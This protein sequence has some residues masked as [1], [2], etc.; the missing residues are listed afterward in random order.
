MSIDRYARQ[1]RLFGDEGQSRIMRSSVLVIGAG[2]LGST[3]SSLL[4]RAG[5]GRLRICDDDVISLHNLP[6]Q[7]LYDEDDLSDEIKASEWFSDWRNIGIEEEGDIGIFFNRLD[8]END[9]PVHGAQSCKLR[10][11][12]RK[13]TEIID[14]H[15]EWTW[16]GSSSDTTLPAMQ[17]PPE[18]DESDELD[19]QPDELTYS[20]HWV[21][22]KPMNSVSR[23]KK[24]Q[25]AA[26]KLR[27]MNRDCYVEPYAVKVSEQ[28]FSSLAH[29]MD[30]IIDCTDDLPFRQTLNRLCV[31]S[32]KPWIY[33][34]VNGSLAMVAAFSG[35]GKPCFSCAFGEEASK[36]EPPQVLN[37]APALCASYQSAIALKA[38]AFQKL[39]SVLWTCDPWSG[40]T[41]TVK[42]R[43]D[44]DCPICG[45]RKEGE[46]VSP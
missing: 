30:L 11:Y 29:G 4:V 14:E 34:G 9:C 46:G 13:L 40:I 45:I 18:S 19:E 6:R 43:P 28:N 24:I 20:Y 21:E 23:I 42:L 22:R 12:I 10:R 2:A 16:D 39:E 17:V 44:P 3:V 32:G 7:L 36:Q 33:G 27:R 5:V 31:L 37:A 1:R 25:I 35:S 15:K 38:L 8:W 26:D 41:S